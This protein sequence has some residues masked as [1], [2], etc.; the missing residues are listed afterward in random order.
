M[1]DFRYR[2]SVAGVTLGHMTTSLSETTREP[3]DAARDAG[4]LSDPVF[5][6]RYRAMSA[7]DAR[8]DGQFITGVH[9]TGIYCLDELRNADA[10][11]RGEPGA[12]GGPGYWAR[13]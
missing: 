5:A 13:S 10:A 4:R 3:G 6:Q 8:F 9:S 11:F 2:M 12:D 7:R 1:S